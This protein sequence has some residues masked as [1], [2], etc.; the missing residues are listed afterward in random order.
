MH[1]GLHGDI[2]RGVVS[3][4][5]MDESNE[6]VTASLTSRV[7]QNTLNYLLTV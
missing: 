4:M 7:K 3:V 6:C 2:E 5:E 1:Y